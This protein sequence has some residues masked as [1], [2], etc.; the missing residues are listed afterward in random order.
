MKFVR[1]T[2]SSHRRLSLSAE[3]FLLSTTLFA[4]N[5][6]TLLH[7]S[8]GPMS[9]QYVG[10]AALILGTAIAL[11][12]TVSLSTRRQIAAQN[13]RSSSSGSKRQSKS[14]SSAKALAHK[15]AATIIAEKS[16]S[17]IPDNEIV[18]LMDIGFQL[19]D[20][21]P[22]RV[23]VHAPCYV[24]GDIHGNLSYL[25]K[26]FS[27][28]HIEQQLLKLQPPLFHL[29]FLGD[30]V[31]RGEFSLEVI[32]LLVSL[33]ILFWDKITLLRGNHEVEEINAGY[34]FKEEVETKRGKG[35][36]RIYKRCNNLFTKL[37]MCAIISKTF[38]CMH[39]G[40]PR[41]EGWDFLM[42]DDFHK[43][44]IDVEIDENNTF[45]DLLWA[46]PTNNAQE[47]RLCK[48]Y[49]PDKGFLGEY[50][51]YRFN[52]ARETSIQFNDRFAQEFFNRFPHIRGIFRAHENQPKGHSINEARTICTVFSSPCYMEDTD[53][54][55]VLRLSA[56]LKHIHFITL[57][58]K[59]TGVKLSQE[60]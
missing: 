27:D 44:K 15:I 50:G 57:K 56:D 30:Y 26:Y 38:L 29:L 52:A 40:L 18:Q 16:L 22:A 53:C 51:N 24:F 55:S 39:G 7:P 58:P 3:Q 2:H 19:L 60:E 49:E 8:A 47:L 33:K 25:L 59:A 12:Q 35:H 54:G 1:A 34:T 42:G 48:D 21:E 11:F 32:A 46:D 31:D 4:F 36:G 45:C 20:E 14:P 10:I 17:S 9:L 28:T 43:P 23:D 13:G 37:P 5:P 6:S 41:P